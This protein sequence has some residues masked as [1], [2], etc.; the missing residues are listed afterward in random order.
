MTLIPARWKSQSPQEA[1]NPCVD[2]LLGMFAACFLFSTER[3]SP[4]PAEFMG[5]SLFPGFS[6]M[7]I[8]V[9]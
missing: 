9:K 3:C 6:G 7:F 5:Y 1:A 2:S 4:F 8:T